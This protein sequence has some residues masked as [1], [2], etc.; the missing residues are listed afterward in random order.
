MEVKYAGAGGIE[1][2]CA[3]TPAPPDDVAEVTEEITRYKLE[4]NIPE[5]EPFVLVEDK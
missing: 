2:G 1:C 4:P 3:H 5:S